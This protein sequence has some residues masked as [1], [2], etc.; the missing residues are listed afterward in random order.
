MYRSGPLCACRPSVLQQ[1]QGSLGQGSGAGHQETA[2]PE[3]SP[4]CSK[5]GK[6]QGRGGFVGGGSQAVLPPCGRQEAF[7]MFL[8]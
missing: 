2:G 5:V 1:L 6:G 4:L 8:E 7:S 3:L